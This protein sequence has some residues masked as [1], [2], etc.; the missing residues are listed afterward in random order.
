MSAERST[1]KVIVFEWKLCQALEHHICTF[2]PYLDVFRGVSRVN[3]SFHKIAKS[4]DFFWATQYEIRL[5]S[6]GK[7]IIQDTLEK[8]N[9]EY[10]DV[11][12]DVMFD[13]F[14]MEELT[15]LIAEF[16]ATYESEEFQPSYLNPWTTWWIFTGRNLEDEPDE[17]WKIEDLPRSAKPF[18]LEPIWKKELD[19]CFNRLYCRLVSG[20][21]LKPHCTG[22]EFALRMILRR[23]RW[24]IWFD[25]QESKVRLTFGPPPEC[26][27]DF[28]TE[29]AW[30]KYIDVLENEKLLKDLDLDNL[31]NYENNFDHWAISE[32]F[33]MMFNAIN[34][35]P[36]KWFIEFPEIYRRA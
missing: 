2:V 4:F 20:K 26:L 24:V 35:H 13:M 27:L 1:P 36:S 28:E 29:E 15:E 17:L 18:A 14:D 32:S 9:F 5:C 3:K 19:M 10:G 12:D 21:G 16:T 22:E 8:Y 33:A 6:Y 25:V 30:L 34:L 31:Y 23:A 7:E 11:H